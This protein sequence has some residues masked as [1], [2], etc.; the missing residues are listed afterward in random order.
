VLVTGDD[1]VAEEMKA[2]VPEIETAVVKRA[3]H[4]YAA[5]C[6]PFGKT[7]PMIREAA[8][9]AVEKAKGVEPFTYQGPMDVELDLHNPYHA[10]IFP[11]LLPDVR[12][13]K[14]TVYYQ[15]KD[16]MDLYRFLTLG[17]YLISSPLFPDW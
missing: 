2:A 17:L 14:V 6:L 16:S 1:V 13:E 5:E 7:L 4:R 9:R 11:R 10:S 8:K 3:I 12:A 15:A